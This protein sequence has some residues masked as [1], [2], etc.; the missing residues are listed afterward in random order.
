MQA[1]ECFALDLLDVKDLHAL[2]VRAVNLVLVNSDFFVLF[3]LQV[4]GVECLVKNLFYFLVFQR[5]F[6]FMV[7]ADYLVQL[8]SILN[9]E[10]EVKRNAIFAEPVLALLQLIQ[11]SLVLVAY[12]TVLFVQVLLQLHLLLKLDI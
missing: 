9:Q 2:S 4:F 1:F 6:A 7:W 12:L 5:D 3:E 10:L 11:V 8:C